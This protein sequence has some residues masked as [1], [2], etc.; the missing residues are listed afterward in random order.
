MLKSRPCFK[1]RIFEPTVVEMEFATEFEANPK[2]INKTRTA[3][4]IIA[5][6]RSFFRR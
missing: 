3:P 4:K 5:Q 1:L 2:L 6:S